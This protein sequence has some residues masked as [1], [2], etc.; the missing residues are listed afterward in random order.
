MKFVDKKLTFAIYF[1][2]QHN[3]TLAES[4]KLLDSLRKR[5]VDEE[6][7]FEEAA[8]NFSSEKE[9][10]NNGGKIINPVTGD[11]SFELTKMDPELYN[12]VKNMKEGEISLPLLTVDRSGAQKY[13]ILKIV[14]RYDEHKPDYSKDY[15]KIKELALKDKQVRTVTKMDERKN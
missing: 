5:I 11:T 10:S 2:T 15:T 6:I 12:Q 3:A 9:T 1:N 14:K 4:K 13:K 8:Y 7:T